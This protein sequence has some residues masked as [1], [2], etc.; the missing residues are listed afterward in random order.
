MAS[1]EVLQPMIM[2][3]SRGFWAIGSFK[4]TYLW[5]VTLFSCHKLEQINAKR[6]LTNRTIMFI[7]AQLIGQKSHMCWLTLPPTRC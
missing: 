7:G 1:R 6:I 2:K 5:L 3:C 4:V